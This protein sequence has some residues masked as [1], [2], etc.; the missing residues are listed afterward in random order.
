MRPPLLEGPRLR[1]R[2]LSCHSWS[3]RKPWGC[4]ANLADNRDPL[5]HGFDTASDVLGGASKCFKVRG[6]ADPEEHHTALLDERQTP[7]HRRRGMRKRLR[8]RDPERLTWLLLRAALDDRDVAESRLPCAEEDAFAAVCLEER[9]VA[10]GQGDGERDPWSPSPG[11][12]IHNRTCLTGDA[13]SGPEGILKQHRPR[14]P[15]IAE[16]GQTRVVENPREPAVEELYAAFAHPRSDREAT[17]SDH[18]VSVGLGALAPCFDLGVV[19]Q[20]LVYE[21][22]LRR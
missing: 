9:D 20:R 14:R 4:R 7:L 18:D 17:R 8:E 21:A 16:R 15:L 2:A 11:A 19:L 10:V 1:Q 22:A 6:R 12:D 13:R 5:R 3:T